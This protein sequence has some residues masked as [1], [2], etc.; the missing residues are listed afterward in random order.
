MES[1]QEGWDGGFVDEGVGASTENGEHG[2][3][4]LERAAFVEFGLRKKV[5]EKAE[6][7]K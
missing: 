4:Q 3:F 2:G 6:G 5:E 1:F 7:K